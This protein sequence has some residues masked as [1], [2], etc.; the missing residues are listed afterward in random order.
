MI[1]KKIQLDTIAKIVEL[2]KKGKTRREIMRQTGKSW[3]TVYKYQK[4]FN[5]I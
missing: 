5:L 4:A 3:S 1:K 2:T